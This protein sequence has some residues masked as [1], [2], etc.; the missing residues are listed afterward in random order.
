[1]FLKILQNSQENTC[2]F[3]KKRDCGTGVFLWILQNFKNTFLQNTSKR[4]LLGRVNIS[5]KLQKGINK[6]LSHFPHFKTLSS[7]LVIFYCIATRSASNSYH[8]INFVWEQSSVF[9][10]GGIFITKIITLL[11]SFNSDLQTSIYF[12]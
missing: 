9:I 12:P 5:I 10:L 3:M 1:M 11:H 8:Y 4:L 2:N 7:F 6:T